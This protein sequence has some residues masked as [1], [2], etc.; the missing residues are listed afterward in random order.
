[1]YNVFLNISYFLFVSIALSLIRN[2]TLW[3]KRENKKK[4][5]KKNLEYLTNKTLKKK[6][7]K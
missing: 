7:K 4:K 1:M 3:K 6:K 5:K 2:K